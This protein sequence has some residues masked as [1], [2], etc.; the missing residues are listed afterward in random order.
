MKR[1]DTSGLEPTTSLI[2]RQGKDCARTVTDNREAA[3]TTVIV[4]IARIKL[5]RSTRAE[6]AAM[7]FSPAARDF[8]AARDAVEGLPMSGKLQRASRTKEIWR[9]H[10]NRSGGWSPATMRKAPRA[11]WSTARR[12]TS[13]RARSS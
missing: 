2:G 1:E 6:N 4:V 5:G 7:V 13:T 10:P 12:P 3:R 11:S 9:K 8:L